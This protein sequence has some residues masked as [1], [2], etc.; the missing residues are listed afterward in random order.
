MLQITVRSNQAEEMMVV[1]Q[2]HG[3]G[4][5]RE[6]VREECE[7]LCNHLS[8]ASSDL[9]ITSVY[10]QLCDS[11]NIGGRSGEM[12]LL[13]GTGKLTEKLMGV[14]FCISPNAFFQVSIPYNARY[15]FNIVLMYNTLYR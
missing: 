7:R 15:L 4:L 12:E 6:E 11:I 5:R 2:L 1:L 13:S 8:G 3:Q 10:F 9:K 14:Q